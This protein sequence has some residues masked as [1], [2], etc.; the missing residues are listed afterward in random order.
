[1]KKT[2]DRWEAIRAGKIYCAPACGG[3]CKWDD[4]VKAKKSAEKLVKQLGGGWKGRVHENLGWYWEA[5]H[6]SNCLSVG[7]SGEDWV[8]FLS[9]SLPGGRWVGH[10]NTPEGAI[11][12]A[13]QMA[14]KELSA[15]K[16]L[17]AIVDANGH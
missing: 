4:Y 8:A 14:K 13:I 5:V 3:R 1:M 10:A 6:K 2:Y 7:P 17:V 16:R 12:D 15:I 9:E 11:S